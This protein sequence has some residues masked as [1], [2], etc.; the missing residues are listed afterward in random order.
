MGGQPKKKHISVGLLAHV[1]AGK[2]TLT[3]ALLYQGGSLRKLGRVD[4]GDAFLDT[5]AQE[6][7]RG[8]TIFSKQ[9]RLRLPQL[10]V[11]L[12][13]TPGH[14]DFST[15][16]ERTL[17][18]LDYAILVISG[19]DGIQGHTR[20]L[21]QLL[22]RHQ[23]PTFLFVNKM[24]LPGLSHER[25]LELLQR[26]DPRCVDF[27]QPAD[28]L[29]ES[30]ALCGEDALS[31]YLETG[32]LTDATLAQ[33][34]ARRQ[35]LPCFFGA[36]LKLEGVDALLEALQRWTRVP[37]YP[38]EFGA[39]V[40]KISRDSQGRRLTH[41]K[42]TG[43][44]LRVKT[45]LHGGEGKDAWQ[46]KA[47]QLRLYSSEKFTVVE[48]LEAGAVC[49]VV[50]LTRTWPGMGLGIEPAGDLPQLEPVLT[51]RVRLP[52]GADPTVV[53]RQL[54]QLEEEDP[55][56]RVSWNAQWRELHVQ[57]MGEV[58]LEVLRQRIRE[59]FALEVEFDAGSIVYRETV[60][61]PVEGV[62]HYEPL[63]HYAE[64]HVL[65][66]PAP[67]GSG[68]SFG[69]ECSLNALDRNWQRLI[70]TH[71]AEKEHLGVLTGS[72]ITDMRLTLLSGRA[73]LKHTEGGDFRQATYRAIRQGLMSAES[74]LLE[75][76]YRFTMELPAD[77]VGRAMTDLE[78]MGAA[79]DPPET[80]GELT[81]LTG[82]APV[83]S[84]RGYALELTAYSR[85]LGR[86]SM[87]GAGYAPCH[88]AAEVI[89][90]IG[91]D[92]AADLEN[93]PDSVFCAHGAGFV[94]P[95]NE[96]PQ[97]MHLPAA[98]EPPA[99]EP[100][101]SLDVNA[102]RPVLARSIADDKELEAIFTRTYGAPQRRDL[103]YRRP[104]RYETAARELQQE[105]GCEE[106]LL[107]DGYN[108]LFA[109]DELNAIARESIEDARQALMEILVNYQAFRPC[110]LIL[111]FDAYR[112]PRNTG[113]VS[114]FHDMYVVYTREAETADQYIEKTT[115]R[116]AGRRRVRV[117][118]SDGIEQL[119]ILGHG[120][121]RIS[122]RLFEEEVRQVT[123]QIDAVLR[124]MRPARNTPLAE[125]PVLRGL[126]QG[127]STG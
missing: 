89:A 85:G 63:R 75:P 83:A 120:A 10:D 76:F 125:D 23:I 66:E 31:E 84:L 6:R 117:A 46:E 36:A 79:Y 108:I 50:G 98:Y 67:A 74:I 19:T 5:D 82:T 7:A 107:V 14:V 12:L 24:D 65:L 62:G 11:T 92:A 33:M 20:T 101:P 78:R 109:W 32:G 115:Y 3:E 97:H 119:I 90:A 34:I 106:F 127:E 100:D 91:Y 112:V 17:Q 16:M 99:P 28:A 111:V 44:S 43:G 69:S 9:A 47:D 77:C 35:V 123:G 126:R 121:E 48:E 13:D 49:A 96:V 124:S 37:G 30:L 52:A 88:N 70:L 114:K 21:W 4:H 104:Q 15:E 38:A 64:V 110:V 116:L 81:L 22:A 61:A 57:L 58:Q 39:R 60:A 55:M 103:L 59:R 80:A 68:L 51:Y 42:I 45:L 26:Q 53:L 18:V 40:F 86:I 71:F 87:T 54:R 27:S 29:F 56:L 1:D 118:T 73:H 72:P 122:A 25:L 95:W 102:P 8:I 94:V 2:T 105:D 113:A 41:M 93:S